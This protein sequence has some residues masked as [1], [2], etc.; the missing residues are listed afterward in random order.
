M[1]VIS[2]K[3]ILANVDAEP[4]GYQER[5][6][7]RAVTNFNE[8]GMRSVLIESATGSGKTVMAMLICRWLQLLE[9]GLT[10]GWVA[11]RRNLLAQAENENEK[12]KIKAKIEYISMFDRHPPSGLGMIVVDEAQHDATDSMVHIHNVNKPKYI[13]GMTATPFRTDRVKLCFDTVIKDS[14]ISALIRDGHLSPYDHYSIPQWG[15]DHATKLYL[16]DP[17]R[18]GKSLMF[19]HTLEQCGQA[20]QM[21]QDGGVKVDMVTGSTDREAQLAAFEAGHTDVIVNCMVLTEGFDCPA[22]KTVFCR[23]SCKAVTMQMAGRVFRR[24]NSAPIKQIVQS[25]LTRWPMVRTATP[26]LQYVLDDDGSWRSLTINP[27]INRISCNTLMAIAHIK[28]EM[29]KY[30]QNKKAA[31]RRRNPNTQNNDGGGA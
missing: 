11:M 6:I 13:L 27:H 28:T 20:R 19:F 7:T 15:P 31:R 21:L 24:H 29:P 14:G 9:P 12:R 22:L 25:K 30:F 18:W 5:I 4:R 16:A 8:V 1:V 26:H 3:K 2:L 23:D 17:Q 10:I